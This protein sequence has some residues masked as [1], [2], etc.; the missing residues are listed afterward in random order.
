[1]TA[2]KQYSEGGVF[3]S[4]RRKN[5]CISVPVEYLSL[6]DQFRAKGAHPCFLIYVTRTY[7]FA[8]FYNL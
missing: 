5:F 4:S 2:M 1:M 8:V 6:Y 3:I 7:T